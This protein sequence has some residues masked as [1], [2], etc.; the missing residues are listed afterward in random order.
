MAFEP[1]TGIKR[2]LAVANRPRYVRR[3]ANSWTRF[4]VALQLCFFMEP[5]AI[6]LVGVRQKS[7]VKGGAA[8]IATDGKFWVAVAFG[9]TFKAEGQHQKNI[10]KCPS[11]E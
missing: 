3:G 8:K 5:P 7:K 1:N 2:F 4:R 11:F 6:V 9:P 10:F